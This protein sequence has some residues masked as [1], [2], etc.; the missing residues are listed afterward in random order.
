MQ[1][2]ID[3]DIKLALKQGDKATAE[4]L[5]FLKSILINA[6]ITAGHDLTEQEAIKVIRKEIK[7]RI[8]ARDMY[9][10]N[11]RNELAD[12][13][14]FE[15]KLYFRYVPKEMSQDEILKIIEGVAKNLKDYNFGQIMTAV[16]PKVAGKADGQTV[17]ET[18]K[19]YLD[20]KA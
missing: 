13:E 11:N 15:S 2:K 18:V 6:K 1:S 8:E 14:E 20:K 3:N 7:A 12:K 9:R 4:A 5:R 19:I 10:A 16:M 17:S